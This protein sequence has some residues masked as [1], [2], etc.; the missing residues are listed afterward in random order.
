MSIS[1]EFQR[2]HPE[3]ARADT[4]ETIANALLKPFRLACGKTI[5]VSHGTPCLY[6]EKKRQTLISQIFFGAIA[7]LLFPLTLLGVLL[8]KQSKSYQILHQ[9][10]I[11]SKC[12]PVPVFDLP[13]RYAAWIQEKANFPLSEAF[14]SD[15]LREAATLYGT[16]SLE[17]NLF[18]AE[19]EVKI[20]KRIA[21]LENITRCR[22]TPSVLA[23]EKGTE[24][25]DPIRLIAS[26]ELQIEKC[27]SKP[28][29]EAH[30]PLAAICHLQDQMRE[31]INA[32]ELRNLE[33][34]LKMKVGD[35]L[36]R[37]ILQD[38]D[39]IGTDIRDNTAILSSDR[40]EQIL[41][42]ARLA[43][44]NQERLQ[45]ILIELKKRFNQGSASSKNDHFP[46]LLQSPGAPCLY[47]PIKN[48]DL[49]PDDGASA[50]QPRNE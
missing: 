10:F 45:E 25:I 18:S 37:E 21:E 40:K 1:I 9:N 39:Y 8:A 22:E 38:W 4:T 24:N 50:P 43:H 35:A 14:V 3:I 41:A 5:T 47:A 32:E 30:A 20:R 26:V 44:E 48:R 23:H 15:L 31:Q 17:R 34:L 2:Q 27:V 13:K 16:A 46:T 7:F 36:A 29:V 28:L 33:A 12:P 19:N 6:T 11:F 49:A 42:K